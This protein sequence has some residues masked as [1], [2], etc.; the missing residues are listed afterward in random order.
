[1]PKRPPFRSI[2]C[3]LSRPFATRKTF[4]RWSAL[5]LG[6]AVPTL[7]TLGSTQAAVSRSSSESSVAPARRLAPILEVEVGET[8]VL[9]LKKIKNSC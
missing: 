8:S 6:H 2:D 1:M 9:A 4:H 7:S 3:Q 5:D